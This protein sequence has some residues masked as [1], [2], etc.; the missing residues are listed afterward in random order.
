MARA[1]EGLKL[2]NRLMLELDGIRVSGVRAAGQ[3][4]LRDAGATH[5]VFCH[6]GALWVEPEE[7][8]RLVNRAGMPSQVR[9]VAPGFNKAWVPGRG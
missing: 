6:G 9:K 7:V 4:Q 1:L 2:R 5:F 3:L 8:V